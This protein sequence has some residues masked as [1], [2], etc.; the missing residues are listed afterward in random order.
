VA[1][2]P[3]GKTLVSGG[4]YAVRLDQG[5]R[6]A[7]EV[8]LWN[9]ATG[10]LLWNYTAA[11]SWYIRSVAFSPDGKTLVGVSESHLEERIVNNA[12]V[13]N[14]TLSEVRRFDASTGKLLW[15]IEGV[16]RGANSVVTLPDGGR[17]VYC[18]DRYVKLIQAQNGAA[19][20]TIFT[21]TERLIREEP[22]DRR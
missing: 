4:G 8:K 2:A 7:G 9:V 18:D 11:E 10:E 22:R 20:E 14:V 19:I 17:L 13:F 12:R 1:F 15:G 16:S 3:D 21:A 5:I 6:P